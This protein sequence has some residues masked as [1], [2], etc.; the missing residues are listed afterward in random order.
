MTKFTKKH[1]V[2]TFQV[3]IT[4]RL[5]PKSPSKAEVHSA[6]YTTETKDWLAH[7]DAEKDYIHWRTRGGIR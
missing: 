1:S 4:R 7:V 6:H 5:D 2:S 3:H